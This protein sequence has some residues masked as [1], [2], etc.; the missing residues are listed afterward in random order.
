VITCDGYRCD[1]KLALIGPNAV[2]CHGARGQ[3]RLGH[4]R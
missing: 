1:E 2:N 4:D 3:P